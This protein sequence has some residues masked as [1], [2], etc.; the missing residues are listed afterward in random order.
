MNTLTAKLNTLKNCSGSSTFTFNGTQVICSITGPTDCPY[1][2]ENPN[3]PYIKI[4]WRESNV[5]HSKTIDR[6]FSHI[7]EQIITMFILPIDTLKMIQISFYVIPACRN[8][9]FCAVN[10]CLLACVQAGIPL[11]SMFCAVSSFDVEEEVFV[12]GLRDGCEVFCHGFGELGDLQ[13]E[14]ALAMVE[15]VKDELFLCIEQNLEVDLF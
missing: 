6:Y 4:D 8:T 12:Y 3:A 1:R 9:L 2:F 14:K 15:D 7:I 11:K 13:R 10:A 5:V